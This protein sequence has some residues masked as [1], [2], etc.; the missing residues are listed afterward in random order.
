MCLQLTRIL[1]TAQFY[2]HTRIC[3]WTTLDA[4]K[5]GKV[6]SNFS[7]ANHKQD[8]TASC[9]DCIHGSDQAWSYCVLQL[10]C[11]QTWQKCSYPRVVL[12]ATKSTWEYF[13]PG[14]WQPLA[15][16]YNLVDRLKMQVLSLSTSLYTGVHKRYTGGTQ[17][18]DANPLVPHACV[19]SPEQYAETFLWNMYLWKT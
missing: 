4:D 6:H 7:K 12:Q 3:M 17:E 2:S 5:A 10:L 15:H 11:L 14:Y 13:R 9:R 16:L 8:A 1:L 19:W 18:E